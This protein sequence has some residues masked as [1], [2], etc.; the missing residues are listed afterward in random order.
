MKWPTGGD[1][2]LRRQAHHHE[3]FHDRRGHRHGAAERGYRAARGYGRY[4]GAVRL[5]GLPEQPPVR[6]ERISEATARCRSRRPRS[7]SPRAGRR[8][9]RRLR[10]GR[11]ACRGQGRRRRWDPGGG[12]SGLIPVQ[13]ADRPDGEDREAPVVLRTRDQRRHPAQG[14]HAD[15]GHDRGRQPRPP[16][17]PS[18]NS[19]IW[20]SLATCSTSAGRSSPSCACGR[21]RRRRRGVRAAAAAPGIHCAGRCTSH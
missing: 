9:R 1:E 12:R 5:G 13:P 2:R 16:T 6:S 17:R 19:P 4:R 3:P 7:S 14:R 11:G 15:R 18:P 21:P 20:S 10:P 8:W